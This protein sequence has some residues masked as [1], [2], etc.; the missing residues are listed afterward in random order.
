MRCVVMQDLEFQ[1]EKKTFVCVFFFVGKYEIKLN[2][3]M[4]I[5]NSW[6]KIYYKHSLWI[7]I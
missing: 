2:D 4:I 3:N 7:P 6:V 5:I 1:G